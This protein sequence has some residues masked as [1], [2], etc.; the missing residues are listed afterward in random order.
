MQNRDDAFVNSPFHMTIVGRTG[1]GKTVVAN[2][3]SAVTDRLSVFFNSQSK[4]Y[5]RGQAI[6]YRGSQDNSRLRSAIQNGASILNVKPVTD[7]GTRELD[8]LTE[9]MWPLAEGDVRFSLFVDE[10]QDIDP[11]LL[12]RL[13]KRGRDPGAGAGGIKMH[14]ISQR[15]T[16]IPKSARTETTYTV[17][18]GVPDSG[19]QTMLES[20]KDVPFEQVQSLH[21]EDRWMDT[22]EGGETVSRAFSVVK[23]GRIVFGPTMAAQKY[24]D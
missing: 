15:F 1:R 24:A 8:A 17:L 14:S 12:V 19:D 23:D 10:A 20:Q 2:Q 16:T 18:V 4:G 6:R 3:I 22:V 9:W 11:D 7:D 21:A 5:V 13:H